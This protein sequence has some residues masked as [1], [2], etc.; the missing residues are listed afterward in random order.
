[1]ETDDIV[2]VIPEIVEGNIS[3]LKTTNA[4]LWM[5]G[6]SGL[7]VGA[8]VS[9]AISAKRLKTKY[10]TIADEEV[11]SVKQRYA[12]LNKEGK[13]G[14]LATLAAPYGGDISPVAEIIKTQDYLPYDQAP[15]SADDIAAELERRSAQ[16]EVDASTPETNED[17]GT[18]TVTRNIFE[19]NDADTFFDWDEEIKRREENPEDPYVITKEEFEQGEKDYTQ[20]TL[21]WFDGDDTLS[22]E[23]DKTVDDTD[24]TVGDV[25]LLRFGHGSKDGNIVYVRNERLEIDIEVVK[26]EGKFAHEVLGF[27]E[28]SDNRRPRRFRHDD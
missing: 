18:L 27:I 19:S 14:D 24:R 9:Y 10:Q 6:V 17:E 4:K 7:A 22:D 21:T 13:Y 1:M 11:A 15:A 26:S 5:I 2:E 8:A 3:W 28:H 25:N 20:V 23:N 16:E 12:M